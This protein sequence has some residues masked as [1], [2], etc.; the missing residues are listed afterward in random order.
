[1]SNPYFGWHGDPDARGETARRKRHYD[2]P[3]V[4]GEPDRLDLGCPGCGNPVDWFVDRD[5]SVET[6]EPGTKRV[7]VCDPDESLE[8]VKGREPEEVLSALRRVINHRRMYG[9]VV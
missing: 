6:M 2:L 8:Y 5:G 3:G 9:A 1:M 7:H 4:D